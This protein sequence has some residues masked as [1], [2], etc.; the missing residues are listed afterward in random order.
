MGCCLY[1]GFGTE[2]WLGLAIFGAVLVGTEDGTTQMSV[3]MA[4]FGR[5]GVRVASWSRASDART[6]LNPSVRIYRADGLFLG[7]WYR[8]NLTPLLPPPLHVPIA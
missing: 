7:G 6:Q 3:W 5:K 4:T 8:Q 1:S 2:L